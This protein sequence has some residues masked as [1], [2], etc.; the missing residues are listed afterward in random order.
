[1]TPFIQHAY[2]SVTVTN[3][4]VETALRYFG[5]WHFTL[6]RD[7]VPSTVFHVFMTHLFRN[8]FADEMGD[9]LYRQYVFIANIPYR[10][11]VPMLQHGTS[12]WFDDVTTP[13]VETRDEI[14]RKSL[15]ETLAE[16]QSRFGEQMKNWR[17]GDLHSLT[18]RHPLGV[19]EPLGSAFNIGPYRVGGSGT[20][21]NNAEYDETHPYAVLVGPSMRQITDFSDLD[22][23][24]SVITTGSSGQ[25]MNDH[26]ADQ[27]RLW[28]YGEYHTLPLSTTAVEASVRHRLRLLPSY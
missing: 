3:P 7:D 27:T 4:L 24:L 12:S 17:W 23:A 5:N 28:L 8:I 6:N 21:V 25:V 13:R 9:T 15:E 19:R 22:N 10:V 1:V 26:Y 16:L 2:D 18:L 11:I 14:I 20:T